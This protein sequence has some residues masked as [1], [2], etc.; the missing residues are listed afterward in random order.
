MARDLEDRRYLSVAEAAT[1]LGCPEDSLRRWIWQRR[2]RSYR[3]GRAVR[4]LRL[5]DLEAF[6]QEVAPIR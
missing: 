1:Y 5:T 4:L 3:L 6:V 2:I